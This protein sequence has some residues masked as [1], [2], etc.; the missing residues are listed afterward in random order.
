MLLTL[1]LTALA[2]PPTWERG[3]HDLTLEVDPPTS[4]LLASGQVT[5]GATVGLIA[6]IACPEDG[7]GTGTLSLRVRGGIVSVDGVGALVGDEM[8]IVLP[9]QLQS[10]CDRGD[11]EVPFSVTLTAP[12]GAW[13][14][15]ILSPEGPLAVDGGDALAFVFERG[16][17]SLTTYWG[18]KDTQRELLRADPGTVVQG[19]STSSRL[20][21]DSTAFGDL[22]PSRS[23]VR[24]ND[25]TRLGGAP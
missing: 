3:P 12:G 15:A 23:V 5:P 22:G 2:T 4:A 11:L 20:S 24:D 6:S 1:V 8:A 21:W 13:V 9:V 14:E 25:R 16:S 18:M 19:L 7:W 17:A 10:R